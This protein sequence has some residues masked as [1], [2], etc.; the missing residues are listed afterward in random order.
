MVKS[1]QGVNMALE[2]T[3]L[4]NQIGVGDWFI[5]F[6]TESDWVFAMAVP[7]TTSSGEKEIR[8]TIYH[9]NN[10]FVLD[11]ATALA[12]YNFKRVKEL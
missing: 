12:N 5:D 8:F 7:Y 11:V 2:Y 10:S 3:D 9:N 4:P 6:T 1:S